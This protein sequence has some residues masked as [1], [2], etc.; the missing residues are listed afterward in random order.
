VV[1]VKTTKIERLAE[2]IESAFFTLDEED[3]K[4][5]EK[6]DAGARLFNP[7]YNPSYNYLPVF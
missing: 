2:N 3:V 4:R 6:L 5:I 1:L 7:V